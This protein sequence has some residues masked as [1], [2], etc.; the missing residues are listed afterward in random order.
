MT[1]RIYIGLDDTDVKGGPFGTGKVAKELAAKLPE[2]YALWAVVRH[3]LPQLPGIPFT[4]HNSP[5]CLM[6]DGEGEPDLDLLAGVAAAHIRGMASPGSDPGLCLAVEGPGLD[7]LT[8]F[9]RET[10]RR[11]VTQDEARMAVAEVGARLEG[12]GGT[13]DGIIGAAAA[14]G[15]SHHGWYGRLLTYKVP[16]AE[17]P[18]PI[19]VGTLRS[20]GILVQSIDRQAF[21]PMDQDWVETYGWLRPYLWGGHP[22]LPVRPCGDPARNGG[23]WRIVHYRSPLKRYLKP[24][25]KPKIKAIKRRLGL[26]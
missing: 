24:I 15:L 6:I 4:S 1:C 14:V 11:V 17:L 23:H 5:A 8:D 7:R 19:Q 25:L 26:A 20:L 2:G 12:L 9:G 18:N 13:N 22:V 16:F 10:S 3:Q 21:I